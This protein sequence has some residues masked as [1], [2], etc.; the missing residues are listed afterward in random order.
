[1]RVGGCR[2]G[3]G[4]GRQSMLR[5]YF[6]SW[7]YLQGSGR[8]LLFPVALEEDRFD[9]ALRVGPNVGVLRAHMS[10]L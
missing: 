5:C 8:T 7:S 2:T 9:A 6:V 10:M 4:A 3:Y 1:M